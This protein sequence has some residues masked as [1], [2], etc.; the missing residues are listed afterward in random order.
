MEFIIQPIQPGDWM[1]SVDVKDAYLHIPNL[2]SY[3]WFLRFALGG[4]LLPVCLFPVRP[5]HLFLNLH[6]GF[7]CSVGSVRDLLR[8]A[9][10]AFTEG[11]AFSIGYLLKKNCK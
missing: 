9:I 5:I 8:Q 1:I 3:Q 6:Q 2:N 7:D 4:E 10:A 11:T